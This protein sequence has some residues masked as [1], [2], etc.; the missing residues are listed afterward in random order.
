MSLKY[1]YPEWL[2][3][4]ITHGYK[5]GVTVKEMADLLLY[6]EKSVMLKL[7]REG[8]YI[9]KSAR[10]KSLLET[11]AE[12][13]DSNMSK[14]TVI[15]RDNGDEYYVTEINASANSSWSQDDYIFVAAVE[16]YSQYEENP[17]DM[18]A[19]VVAEG[20]DCIG[21]FMGE[22]EWLA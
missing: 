8:V 4:G 17:E 12:K 9:S 15:W 18:A 1:P 5:N 20:Y 6:P 2:T 16:E 11:A 3:I 14:Y 22:V 7:S 21:V 13:Q 19:K 10:K